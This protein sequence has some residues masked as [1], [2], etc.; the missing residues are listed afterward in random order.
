MTRWPLR[1]EVCMFIYS[2]F[3]VGMARLL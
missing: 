1:E 3:E 2:P